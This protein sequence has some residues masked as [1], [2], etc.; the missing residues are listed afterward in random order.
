MVTVCVH[1][2]PSGPLQRRTVATGVLCAGH[3]VPKGPCAAAQIGS[4]G[5]HN[6]TSYRKGTYD[7]NRTS[8]TIEFPQTH[9][10]G[11]ERTGELGFAIVAV[12][13]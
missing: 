7:E 12:A 3:L 13:L 10:G 5:L 2:L 8:A 6:P 9:I 1:A 4:D 11:A